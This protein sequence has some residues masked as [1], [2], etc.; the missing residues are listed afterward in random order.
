MPLTSLAFSSDVIL[1]AEKK[2]TVLVWLR[3]KEN[4]SGAD[5]CGSP[6]SNY[7]LSFC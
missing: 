7:G 5:D 1:I 4:E 3:P 2:G 6:I